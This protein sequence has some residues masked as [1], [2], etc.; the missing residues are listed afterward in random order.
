[1]A[2]I[3]NFTEA[4]LRQIVKESNSYREVLR[5]LGYT[6]TGG[7]NNK[8]LQKRL[9]YYQ[10]DISHFKTVKPL[11]RTFENI[12]C[13]NSTATQ[14]VVKRWFIQG[15][16]TEYKC[17]IC[18]LTSWQNKELKLQLD[19][20][21]GNNKDNRLNNLRWLCPNCHSQTDTFCGKQL[22]KNHITSNGVKK[23]EKKHFY[24][25]DCGIEI[26]YGAIRCINCNNI[27][28]RRNQPTKE[29]LEKVLFDLNGNF[30]AVGRKYNISDNG[31][32]KWCKRYGLS[33]YSS[34]YHN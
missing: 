7:N 34:D 27:Y 18:G 23:D 22:K 10:I 9:E 33:H 29:E 24:C 28:N 21:N 3:D 20:I 25:V 5:K 30:S 8:T 31:V 6:T 16:Y 2:K 1:M 17:A 12:F 19:H 4:E 13:E 32:R 15:E 26:S 11:K 14:S